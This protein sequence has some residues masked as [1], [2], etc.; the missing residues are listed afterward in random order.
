MPDRSFSWLYSKCVFFAISS[1]FITPKT[2]NSFQ[3]PTVRRKNT[4]RQKNWRTCINNFSLKSPCAPKIGE[5][6]VSRGIAFRFP[7]I[8]AV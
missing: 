5:R 3:Y 8:R 6:V 4:E 1:R 7:L 2:V